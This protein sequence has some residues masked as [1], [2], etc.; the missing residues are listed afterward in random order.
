MADSSPRKRMAAEEHRQ[1]LLDNPP[2][3]EMDMKK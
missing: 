3:E 1:A 2:P